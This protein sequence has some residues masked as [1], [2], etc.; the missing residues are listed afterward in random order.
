MGTL[1]LE[2]MEVGFD[3]E[4]NLPDGKINEN[5]QVC[6]RGQVRTKSITYGDG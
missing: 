4:Q 6:H 5:Y 1:F 2:I 3:D